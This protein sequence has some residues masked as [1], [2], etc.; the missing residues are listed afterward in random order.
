VVLGRVPVARRTIL[1]DRRRLAIAVAGIGVALGLIFLL[2]G[3]WQ[4]FQ[5][6]ISAY[7][8]KAGADLFV[9]QAGTHNFLGDTSTI[10]AATLDQVRATPGVAQA[11]GITA[12]FTILDLHQAKQFAF[13][14]AAPRG[15][16][17]GPWQLAAGRQV[18]ADDEVVI[19]HT[20]ADQHSIGLGDRI[21]L[22]GASLR[23]VGL[24]AETRS[25]MSSFVFVSPATAATLLQSC[26]RPRRWPP[27]TGRCWARSWVVR[28]P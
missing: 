14:I 28:S 11:D 4:G 23:V 10:P 20:L 8:D 26:C 25:W 15:G 24:S 12:R 2:E 22:L 5:E 6:Q 3:L 18:S 7:E 27:T 17:G 21:E 19:D 9:G 13:L 16:I 1:A